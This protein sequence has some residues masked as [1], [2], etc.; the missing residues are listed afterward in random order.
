MN[1][2]SQGCSES[3]LI[4][5]VAYRPELLHDWD[6]V[7]DRSKNGVFLHKRGYMDYH[8]ER[9]NDRS[10][11][12]FRDNRAIAVFPSNALGSSVVSHGGLTY[13]GLIY[14][15]ELHAITVLDIYKLIVNHYKEQ[16]TRRIVFKPIPHVFHRYP[17][18]EEL[19]SLYRVGARLFRRDLSSVIDL[20]SLP[21]FS[22][23]R[24][25]AARKAQKIG[26]HFTETLDFESF[27]MLLGDV[28]KKFS[29][30]P[31]H[32]ANELRLLQSRFP[33][34][35]R[36]FAIIHENRLIAAALIY[37]FGHIMHT[38]YMAASNE[39]RLCGAL[40][41]LLMNLIEVVFRDRQYFS[42]GISTEKD[43]EVLNE[44][45]IWQKE[46]FGGRGIVHDFYGLDL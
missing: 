21:K 18:E 30:L 13:G 36:L 17:A 20:R 41:Y 44:G 32:T 7:V 25:S 42:F 16:G 28:L 6:N 19:Y 33:D 4:S 26:A 40:D 34:Q 5:L 37:D 29:V 46:G 38:Q 27:L 9:F 24:K 11:L 45:L 1:T 35:I 39:G 3:S 14:G 31:V 8:S 23:S 10:L 43:G 22:D 2:N 12:I 15:K